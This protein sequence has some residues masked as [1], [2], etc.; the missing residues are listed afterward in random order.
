M[1]QPDHELVKLAEELD[2]AWIETELAP[3]YSEGWRPSVPIRAMLG[4]LLLK[5]M[6]N[7]SDESVLDR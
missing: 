2:W 3:L 4:M 6:F 5:R 1:L 7:Q